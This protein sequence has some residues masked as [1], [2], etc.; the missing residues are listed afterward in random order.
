[1]P[2]IEETI[3]TAGQ[4]DLAAIERIVRDAF[5]IYIPRMDREPGPML[6]DY[7]AHVAAGN[8]FVLDEGGQILGLSVLLDEPDHLLLDV[9]AVD[10]AAQGK[11]VGRRLVA[12][13]EAEAAR[14]GFAEVRLYTNE[15]MEEVVSLYRHLGF[16]ETHRA[17]DGG[18]RRIFMAKPVG[19]T[20]D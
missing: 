8:A 18:Y 6:Q 16:V 19:I 15:A 17:V 12:H 14:R 2:H 11:G 4:G 9:V 20:Q 7:A 1:M 13:C 3:R 10:P 5:S